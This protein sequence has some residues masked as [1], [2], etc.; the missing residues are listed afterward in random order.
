VV[1]EALSAVECNADEL[2][3]GGE[4]IVDDDEPLE[5]IVR[6][7]GAQAST[8][9]KADQTSR[10]EIGTNETAR[11]MDSDLLGNALCRCDRSSISTFLSS[12]PLANVVVLLEILLTVS[13]RR[14][15]RRSCGCVV[16][17]W[18]VRRGVRY[19]REE[20]R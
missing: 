10:M 14:R 4:D 5:E 18:S 20:T 1:G 15:Q 8:Y 16:E 12:V 9:R 6:T 3:V 19:D 13:R 7:V 17:T 2:N 11:L